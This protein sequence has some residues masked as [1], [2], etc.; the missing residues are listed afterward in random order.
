MSPEFRIMDD[1]VRKRTE[2]VSAVDDLDTAEGIF[3]ASL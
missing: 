1:Y 2:R 3:Y